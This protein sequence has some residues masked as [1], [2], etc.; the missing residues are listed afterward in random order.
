MAGDVGAQINHD[1]VA[2]RRQAGRRA[3]EHLPLRPRLRH[4]RQRVADRQ[5]RE[6]AQARTLGDQQH[7]GRARA[8][9]STKP[10]NIGS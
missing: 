5:Q 10:R 3:G 1:A 8:T 4:Q 9:E 6:L 2:G 7:A